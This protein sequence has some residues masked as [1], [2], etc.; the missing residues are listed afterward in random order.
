MSLHRTILVLAGFL[1]FSTAASSQR[2]FKKHELSVG[3]SPFPTD[4]FTSHDLWFVNYSGV[5][6]DLYGERIGDEKTIPLF[7]VSYNHFY[8]RWFSLDTRLSLSG[9]YQNVYSGIDSKLDHRDFNPCVFATVMAQFTYLNRDWVRLY[10]SIGAGL[11]LYDYLGISLHATLFGI[12][13]GK[14]VFGFAECG[15]GAEYLLLHA[16]IGYRF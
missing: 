7:S 8:K 2:D 15:L 13:V 14:S 1:A 12:S 16:G 10:S 9:N 6:E 3:F 11:L 4:I 5:L